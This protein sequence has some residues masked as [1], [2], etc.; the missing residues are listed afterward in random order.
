MIKS[1]G[2]KET[3]KIWNGSYSKKLPSKIQRN[4]QMKLGMIN[5]VKD[6]IELKVPPGNKLHSLTGDLKGFNSIKIN[7]Q[8]RIIFKFSNGNAFE[9]RITDYH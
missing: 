1:F 8:W 3:E 4:A 7:D 9:V 5:N 6:I 2:D